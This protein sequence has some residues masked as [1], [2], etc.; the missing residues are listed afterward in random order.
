[1]SYP[2]KF[3]L[4]GL[5]QRSPCCLI[6]QILLDT[7]TIHSTVIMFGGGLLAIGGWI[8]S[9]IYAYQPD[10]KKWVKFGDLPI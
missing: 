8:S 10:S 2:M 4:L 9:D 5:L 3:Q 6:W 1:M 7:P